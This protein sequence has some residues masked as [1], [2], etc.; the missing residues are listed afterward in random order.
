MLGTSLVI[1]W[2]RLCLPML[3]VQVRPLIK[4]LRLHMPHGQKKQTEAI[5]QQIQYKTFFLMVHIKK[6]F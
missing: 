2:L 3:R 6:S 1:Q 5:L 4:E